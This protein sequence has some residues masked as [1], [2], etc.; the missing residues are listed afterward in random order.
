MNKKPGL[1]F[2]VCLLAV[3]VLAASFGLGFGGNPPL[4]LHPGVNPDNVL[5]VC[6]VGDS[7]WNQVSTSLGIFNKYASLLFFFAVFVLLFSWGWAF[8]Q[9]LLKDK[10]NESKNE[11]GF[12]SINFY[13]NI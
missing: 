3:I 2:S 13:K 8:Y 1:L 6:P 12:P 10:F 9:N 4:K 5:Y 11:F 7:V